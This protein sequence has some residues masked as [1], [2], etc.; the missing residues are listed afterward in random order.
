[1]PD[2]KTYIAQQNDGQQALMSENHVRTVKTTDMREVVH[3]LV[4]IKDK[5]NKTRN[6]KSHEKK[7]FYMQRASKLITEYSQYEIT[8]DLLNRYLDVLENTKRFSLAFRMH[9]DEKDFCKRMDQYFA[10]LEAASLDFS[11]NGKW[12]KRIKTLFM[13]AMCCVALLVPPMLSAVTK[14]D[15]PSTNTIALIVCMAAFV[16]IGIAVGKQLDKR[17]KFSMTLV[18]CF[19]PVCTMIPLYWISVGF[20]LW[21]SVGAGMSEAIQSGKLS[22]WQQI[23]IRVWTMGF[24]ILGIVLLLFVIIMVVMLYK[25]RKQFV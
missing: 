7:L 16:G 4:G 21:G 8:Y 9:E 6:I 17:K 23:Y 20:G 1:M 5:I 10:F 14:S 13:M 12:L 2:K 18:L 25:N 11:G 24:P 3:L 15:S 19:V 22:L